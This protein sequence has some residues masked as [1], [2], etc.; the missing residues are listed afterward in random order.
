MM[1][2]G[3]MEKELMMA[4]TVGTDFVILACSVEQ[5]Q[6]PYRYTLRASWLL[7]MLSMLSQLLIMLSMLTLLSIDAVDAVDTVDRCCR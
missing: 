3:F 2:V 4:S 7:M 6:E 5:K 1:G